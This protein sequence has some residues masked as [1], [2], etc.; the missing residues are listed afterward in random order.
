MIESFVVGALNHLLG[1][2]TWARKQLQPFAGRRARFDMPPWQLS[3]AVTADGLFEPVGEGDVDV[4]VTLPAETP[5][6][7]L[8]GV[9]H[10]MADAHVTGNAEFATALSFVLKHLRW[11]AEEDLSKLVGDVAAHRIA[12]VSSRL[13]FWQKEAGRNLAENLAEYLGEESRLLVPAR[14]LAN[15]REELA[16]FAQRIERLEARAKTLA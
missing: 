11:D 13:T 6:V 4:T 5:L 10:A 1:Q 9:D 3:F 7:A 12:G 8:Q 2:A 16:D 14:E 15:F